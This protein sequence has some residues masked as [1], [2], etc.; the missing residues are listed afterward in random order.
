M[1]PP[2]QGSNLSQDSSLN[3]TP[4]DNCNI[5]GYRYPNE[6]LQDVLDRAWTILS[7]VKFSDPEGETVTCGIPYNFAMLNN[8]ETSHLGEMIKSPNSCNKF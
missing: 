2:S 3:M 8:P 7:V 1:I 4:R 5:S 6:I